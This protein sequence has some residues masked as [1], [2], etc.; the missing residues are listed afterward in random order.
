MLGTYTASYIS[1]NSAIKCYIIIVQPVLKCIV[2][3]CTFHI[4]L[5]NF[6]NLV[7]PIHVQINPLQLMRQNADTEL[8]YELED[9]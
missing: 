2:H 5:D 6:V 3:R 8:I 1:L 4:S 7:L 9:C